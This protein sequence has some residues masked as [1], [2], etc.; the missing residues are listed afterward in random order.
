M[1]GQ[2][3]ITFSSEEMAANAIDEVNGFIL[4]DKPM[5]ICFGKVKSADESGKS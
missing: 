2:A 1:K 5:V 3:F 4:K